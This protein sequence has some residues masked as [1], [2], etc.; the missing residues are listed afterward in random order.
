MLLSAKKRLADRQSDQ[1]IRPIKSIYKEMATHLMTLIFAD[2][3]QQLTTCCLLYNVS[4]LCCKTVN[5]AT[6]HKRSWCTK[7]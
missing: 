6:V 1:L 3:Q 7:Q 5:S 2:Q 4:L